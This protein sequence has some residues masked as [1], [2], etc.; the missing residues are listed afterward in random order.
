[1][2]ASFKDGVLVIEVP[3]AAEARPRKI[4]IA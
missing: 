2:K 3:K 1:V 4:D